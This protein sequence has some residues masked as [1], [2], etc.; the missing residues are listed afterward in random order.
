[1]RVAQGHGVRAVFRPRKDHR[2]QLS[3]LVDGFC[4]LRLHAAHERRRHE[5]APEFVRAAIARGGSVLAVAIAGE[6]TV[7]QTRVQRERRSGVSV[8]PH[9]T[10]SSDGHTELAGS[11]LRLPPNATAQ[12][13]IFMPEWFWRRALSWRRY[14]ITADGVGA[15]LWR[16]AHGRR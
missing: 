11:T 16:I 13:G 9:L 6:V 4:L 2:A 12:K 14:G 10:V 8:L 1:M 15:P 5:L 3:R 7:C